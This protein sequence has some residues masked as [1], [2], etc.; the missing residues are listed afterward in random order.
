MD[1]PKI[2]KL[3]NEI[4]KTK[5]KALELQTKL[6]TM[7][8]QKTALENEQIIALVR[9]KKISDSELAELMRSLRKPSTTAPVQNNTDMEEMY[10]HDEDDYT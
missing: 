7:E 10:N 8:R 5:A 1:N 2:H 4:E 9:S 6:R 3:A